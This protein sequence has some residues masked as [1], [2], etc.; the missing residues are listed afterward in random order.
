MSVLSKLFT[1]S[2]KKF[3]DL[4]EQVTLNLDKMAKVFQECVSIEDR[5]ARKPVLDR[6]EGFEQRNDDATHRLFVELGRNYITPFDREDIHFMASS[7]DD[8]ADY[9]WGT[10]KQMYYF[11]VEA[12][13]KGTQEVA[14]T[15]TEYIQKLNEAIKG[16][17][18]QRDLKAMINILE[19]MRKLTSRSDKAIV[20]AQFDLVEEKTDA[21]EM[22]K[23]HDHYG[24]LQNLNNKCADVINVLEGMVIKYG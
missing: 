4:F 19:Q 16:L 13:S 18:N 17:R 23:L 9:M 10:A 24:M 12:N 22:I 2:G 21:V 6:V 3:Y 11:D 14:A 5:R 20:Q 7:L 1:P 8:I 15:L